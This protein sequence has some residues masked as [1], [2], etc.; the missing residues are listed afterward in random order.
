MEIKL[1]N[2][3]SNLPNQTAKCAENQ[4]IEK[5]Q[6]TGHKKNLQNLDPENPREANFRNIHG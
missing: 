3:L 1:G 6:E 4:K 2:V 5:F